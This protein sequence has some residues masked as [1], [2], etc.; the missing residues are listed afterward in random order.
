MSM[1]RREYAKEM[2]ALSLGAAILP[3][4]G[5]GSSSLVTALD[6]TEVAASAAIPIVQAFAPQIGAATVTEI[7]NYLN[8]VSNACALSI[9][10]A[11][12][13]ADSQ[14]V[15]YT[16]MAG[17][18]AN[19]VTLSLPPGI[20]AEVAAGIGAVIAAVQVILKI[21]NGTPVPTPAPAVVAKLK[22]YQAQVKG[23]GSDKAR[24]ADVLAKHEQLKKLIAR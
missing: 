19:V 11:G 9:T 6:V 24:M 4:T 7:D 3:L 14:A 8:G 10:E 2:A 22:T 12:N 13:T 5:C 1:T 18:F 21:I 23:L 16:K 17:Y 15:Q 20:A